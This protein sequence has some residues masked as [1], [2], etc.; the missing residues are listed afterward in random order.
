MNRWAE[1]DYHTHTH[2]HTHTQPARQGVGVS[3]PGVVFLESIL[4]SRP[5]G[6]SVACTAARRCTLLHSA[7]SRNTERPPTLHSPLHLIKRAVSIWRASW[8]P[9][10]PPDALSVIRWH[11]EKAKTRSTPAGRRCDRG[12]PSNREPSTA[13]LCI[14]IG[15]AP[16]STAVL[17]CRQPPAGP[18]C[19]KRTPFRVRRCRLQKNEKEGFG[20]SRVIPEKLVAA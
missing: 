14:S 2:T 1:H 18:S 15:L 11:P 7:K 13:E 9:G 17:I 4:V 20:H 10:G 6:R 8:L 16:P 3:S 12:R 19:Q 5:L